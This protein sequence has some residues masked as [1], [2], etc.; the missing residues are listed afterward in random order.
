MKIILVFDKDLE[1]CNDFC[2]FIKKFIKNVCTV[3]PRYFIDFV[4]DTDYYSVFNRVLNFL[5][6]NKHKKFIIIDNYLEKHVEHLICQLKIRGNPITHF[7]CDKK[8]HSK[9]PNLTNWFDINKTPELI[10]R[11]IE[12]ENNFILNPTIHPKYVFFSL[13]KDTKRYNII[14]SYFVKNFEKKGFF[15]MR[16]IKKSC[17]ML[18]TTS[19]NIYIVSPTTETLKNQ[20]RNHYLL[21]QLQNEFYYN[22]LDFKL[23]SRF[24]N[25]TKIKNNMGLF[26]ET[27]TF[28][29]L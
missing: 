18:D 13:L 12:I 7:I 9:I 21:L 10:K 19:L 16:F 22:K 11:Y 27:N 5:S 20:M 17:F 6:K 25:N 4:N 23:I 14:F 15:I 28:R 29:I 8:T 26:C 1:K 24:K 2:Y 3:H